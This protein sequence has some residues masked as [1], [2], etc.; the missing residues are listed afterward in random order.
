MASERTEPGETLPYKEMLISADQIDRRIGEM[1]DEIMEIHP[2]SPLFI[3]MMRGGVPFASKLMFALSERDPNYHPKIDYMMVSTYGPNREPSAPRIVLDLSPETN[4]S[5]VHVVLLD[6]LIDGGH[7]LSYV[8]QVLRHRGPATIHSAVLASKK[9]QSPPEHQPDI[10]GFADLP[11][12]WLTGIG[13]DDQR[14]D[15]E[16]NRWLGEIAVAND[17]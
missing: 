17:L 2:E 12:V 8:E 1:A 9:K 16:A 14:I 15:R 5:G 11:D 7:T 3:C 13:M 10:I 4:I 6:D